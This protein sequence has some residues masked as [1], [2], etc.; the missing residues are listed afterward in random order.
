MSA[1]RVP[2]HMLWER[3]LLGGPLVRGGGEG[4]LSARGV[5]QTP[6]SAAHEGRLT[7]GLL[8]LAL[9]T[10]CRPC[11]LLLSP[12]LPSRRRSQDELSNGKIARPR[13]KAGKSLAPS[14]LHPCF[15][16]GL[17]GGGNGNPQQ[18]G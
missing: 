6:T 1:L 9:V 10:S 15:W 4:H 7:L 13:G 11:P 8:S 18:G 5:C 16:L 2:R 17:G 14:P 12:P 3:M